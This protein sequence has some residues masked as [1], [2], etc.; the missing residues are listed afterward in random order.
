MKAIFYLL[1]FAC[2][3]IGCHKADTLPVN[4]NND[5]DGSYLLL[6]DSIKVEFDSLLRWWVNDSVMNVI[7]RNFD[8]YKESLVCLIS[9]TSVISTCITCKKSTIRKGDLAFII[10]DKTRSIPYARLF[11]V[12]FDF[13]SKECPVPIGI[14]DY[15]EGNRNKVK[16]KLGEFYGV[17]V[18][19]EVLLKSPQSN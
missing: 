15:I 10:L 17:S 8:S 12:Q 5:S 7:D 6:H 18:E 11:R 1:V 16:E 2:N 19:C 9:D 3:F 13:I 14:L 4:F